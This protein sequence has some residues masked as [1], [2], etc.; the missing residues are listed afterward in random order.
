[1]T[2][3]QHANMLQLLPGAGATC[4]V[5]ILALNRAPVHRNTVL[6]AAVARAISGESVCWMLQNAHATVLATT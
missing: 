3:Q 1:M 4:R 2:Q 6:E 5:P